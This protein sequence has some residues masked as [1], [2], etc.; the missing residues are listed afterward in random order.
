LPIKKDKI[1]KTKER[2]NIDARLHGPLAGIRGRTVFG[3]Q[4]NP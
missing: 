1:R 4:K 2:E 3:E